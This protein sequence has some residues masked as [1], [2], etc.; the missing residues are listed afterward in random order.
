VNRS[1]LM[2]FLGLTSL[3]LY[4]G[5]CTADVFR[6]VVA[7]SGI[8][9][10]HRS[11]PEKK[12]ILESM[13]GGL[14]ILDF[15]NDGLMDIYLVNALTVETAYQPESA[16]SAL[17]KNLGGLKFEDV[18]EKAGL[19][20][21]GWGMGV[22]TAD[23][24]G[25]SW[26]DI[27][28]TTVGPDKLYRNRGDGTFDDITEESGLVTDGWSTGCGFA[29]YDKD[30]DLDLFVARY[31]EVN[32]DSLPEFGK[33]KFCSYGGVEVQCGPR[34]LPGTGDL[35]FRNRGDETFEQV[36][37]EVGVDDPNQYFGLGIS[38]F[39][40]D[41]DGW[42]DLFV[43]ND[44]G[45]N[46]LY[47]NK[48]DGT[49]EDMAFPMGVAVSEDGAEQGCMGVAVGDYLNEGRLSVFVTNF[50]EEYNAL[51]YNNEAYFTDLSFRSASAPPSLPYVSWGTNFFDYDN[52]GWQDII[53]VSGHVYPQLE[54]A[55]V[56]ASAPYR[57]RKTFY[58]NKRDGRFEE[59]AD[60]LGSAFV[61][62][63]VSRG[64]T[65]V[66]LD[67]DGRLDMVI[68]DL[69]G[70]PQIL[71]NEVPDAGNWLMVKLAGKGKLTDAIGAVVTARVADSTMTRLIR[72]GSSYISQEDKRL[73]FGLGEA[74]GVDRIEVLWPDGTTSQRDNVEANQ[75]ILI[76]QE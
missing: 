50:S 72:S 52:D 42:L 70:L 8:T 63:K 31:V 23:I 3:S 24:D 21:P 75:Q 11:A 76:E 46:F 38:W 35:F 54:T 5:I 6:D 20:F 39:D 65:I 45:P 9:F 10:R 16:P 44:A 56:G 55:P 2:V 27:Y 4:S 53:V 7:D 49:F 1:A 19:A 47:H 13:A 37:A 26:Q 57:Q 67:N 28:V 17:Y 43:A 41:A 69:D 29:D 59:I 64:M 33:G 62:R 66:D 14:A 74:T 12:Y 40:F 61:E 58:R 30:G 51:Y 71:H 48:G 68:S 73:H 22:C 32:L 25:D 36:A 34:G 15:N 60:Q 18:T